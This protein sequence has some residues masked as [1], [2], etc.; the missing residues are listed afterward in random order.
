MQD[1]IYYRLLLIQRNSD[2]QSYFYN[3]KILMNVRIPE[4]SILSN[5]PSPCVR[6]GDTIQDTTMITP[7]IASVIKVYSTKPCP[8][9]VLLVIFYS[10]IGIDKSFILSFMSRNI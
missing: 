7:I 6:L 8:Y 5:C 1:W 4:K 2:N 3:P 10:P 9:S